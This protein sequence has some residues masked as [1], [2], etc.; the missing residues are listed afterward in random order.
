[1]LDLQKACNWAR[2]CTKK[3]RVFNFTRM[4]LY[5]RL[6][7]LSLFTNCQ[8]LAGRCSIPSSFLAL[9]CVYFLFIWKSTPLAGLK[10]VPSDRWF[11][12]HLSINTTTPVLVH[13]RPAHTT[14]PLNMLP[15]TI[16]HQSFYFMRSSNISFYITWIHII[17]CVITMI[18]VA[19]FVLLQLAGPEPLF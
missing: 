15:I 4:P 8:S 11:S 13:I 1:M 9:Y 7:F 2:H 3:G 6:F 14:S 18:T 5:R 16:Q 19:A 10:G 12:F 17:R